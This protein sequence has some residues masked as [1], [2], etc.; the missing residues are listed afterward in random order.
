MHWGHQQLLAGDNGLSDALEGWCGERGRGYSLA[1]RLE[2]L[3]GGRTGGKVPLM[4]E[5]PYD[6]T[7]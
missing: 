7:Q 1:E 4:N 2:K 5:S 6:E 3:K